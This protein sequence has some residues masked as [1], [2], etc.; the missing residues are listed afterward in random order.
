MRRAADEILRQRAERKAI[1]FLSGVTGFLGSHLA[2][3]LLK[4]KHKVIL[5][6]RPLKG[7]SARQR[8]DQVLHGLGV[9][10]SDRQD[11][12]VIEGSLREPR[13]GLTENRFLNL[14]R[15]VDEIIH[16]ASDTSFTERKRADVEGVNIGG[17]TTILDLA[18][19]G[20]CYFFHYVSTA[21]AAGRKA[22]I[23]PEELND[24]EIFTNVYEETK[25]RAE[26]MASDLCRHEGIRLSIYR[27][28]V[29][30]GNSENGRATI[31]N[32]FYYP[33]KTV[34]FLKDLYSRDIR[35]REGMRA[36]GM[37]VKYVDDGFLHLPI[38]MEVADGGGVNLIPVD[39]FASAFMAL[40]EECL[41]GGIFHIVSPRLTKIENLI[42]YTKRLFKIDGL[43]PCRVEAFDR[44][45]KNALEILFESY[46]KVY[47]P[48][49]RDTRIFDNRKAQL[50]LDK[51]GIRCPDFD[52]ELF[53]RCAKYAVACEWGKN[54]VHENSRVF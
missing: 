16:C 46:L 44:K 14:S 12:Q 42:D 13:F 25:C 5:L 49:I 18:A 36:Q 6:A 41:S 28:S 47:G 19:I 8:V 21:Y 26:R 1:F 20:R 52:F 11:P 23:C 30:C 38:R 15:D 22:G 45:S 54:A 40:F 3:E 53:S 37:G 24:P 43:E 51:K 10:T 35:E 9:P 4:R 31:F 29:V 39:Y 48:Y 32:G 34:L 27:P 17:M 2:V 50:I 7:L 33:L